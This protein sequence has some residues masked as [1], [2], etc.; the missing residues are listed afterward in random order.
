MRAVSFLSEII[1]VAFVVCSV[2]GQLFKG[3]DFYENMFVGIDYLIEYPGTI[4][5]FSA[6]AANCRWAVE[7]PPGYQ[8][9]ID[10]TDII[11]PWVGLV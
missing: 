6:K 5:N 4:T 10:C 11:M 8:V 2:S 7:A 9:E 1:L 3:C